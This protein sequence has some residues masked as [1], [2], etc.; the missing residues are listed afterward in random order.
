MRIAITGGTGFLGRHVIKH[1]N[2]MS[3]NVVAVARRIG[4]DLPSLTNGRWIEM[5]VGCISDQSY[6]DLGKPDVLIHLAWEGLPQ[7][8]SPHHLDSEFPKHDSFLTR[9]VA[10]GL[11]RVIVAG[12]CF[13][14]GMQQGSLAETMET[15]PMNSYAIAKDLLRQR[16]QQL[17]SQSDFCLTWLRFFYLHGEG[18]PE[19]SLYS[20]LHKAI[21]EK[22]PTFN[23]TGG[24]QVRDYLPVTQAARHVVDLAMLGEDNGIVNVCSGNPRTIRS[25]VEAWV[26]ETRCTIQ[27]NLGH[28][29]YP[30]YEPMEFW[31]NNARLRSLVGTL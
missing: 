20:Q 21:Q 17:K 30:D 7:Y 18:Q 11:P 14:Y 27:L 6:F 10:Q 5:D 16:L 31:G 29:P 12:T 25:I 13:E 1:L 3:V 28:Y 15:Q 8:H 9:M 4:C 22:Q 2:H 24:T 26:T 19:R 23:M